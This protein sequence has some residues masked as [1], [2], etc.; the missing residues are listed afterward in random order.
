M[1]KSLIIQFS[2]LSLLA[3][4]FAGCE[5]PIPPPIGGTTDT[6]ANLFISTVLPSYGGMG[7]FIQIDGSGF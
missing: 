4:T 6:P 5:K 2:L 3:A 7:D 1:K